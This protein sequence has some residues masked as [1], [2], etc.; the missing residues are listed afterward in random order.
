[1]PHS[2]HAKDLFCRFWRRVGYKTL[3]F[4]P[5]PHSPYFVSGSQKSLSHLTHP[6][7]H[8]YIDFMY[9]W[10]CFRPEYTGSWIGLY[11]ISVCSVIQGSVLS[12][13]KL[14]HCI[15]CEHQRALYGIICVLRIF[16]QT[17]LHILTDKKKFCTLY[18][19]S[20]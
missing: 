3:N 11:R 10:T 19:R 15:I 18:T 4:C 9:Y 20:M 6:I 5:Y 12:L 14:L 17:W 8:F 2:L 16:W 7:P 1:M 13:C